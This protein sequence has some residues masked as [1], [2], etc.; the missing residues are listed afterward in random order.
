[1]NRSIFIL[2]FVFT[3]VCLGQ[4][5]AGFN[6]MVKSYLQGTVPLATVE[7]LKL[8]ISQGKEIIILDARE[9]KEYNVSHIKNALFVGYDHFKASSIS[10]I[11]YEI[12]IYVY[13]SVGYRSEKVGEKLIEA[14]YQN[15]H[16]LFG[17]IFNWVNSGNA[18]V[19]MNGEPTRKV[20]GY[21]KEWAKWL[22]IDKSKI[23]LK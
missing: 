3:Q 11:S 21:N 16:N 7:Q 20:H 6:Q 19:N 22:N 13:C 5:P 8:D 17:G 23:V 14:G 18:V 1:M 2:F 12:P 15:V 9:M 4:N 10:D